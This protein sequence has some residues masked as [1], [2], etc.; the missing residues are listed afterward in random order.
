M[1][2]RLHLFADEY[3]VGLFHRLGRSQR[4]VRATIVSRV[5]PRLIW[6][7]SDNDLP[8]RYPWCFVISNRARGRRPLYVGAFLTIPTTAGKSSLVVIYASVSYGWLK[9]NMQTEFPIT[10][11]A[12]R[13][14]N[15]VTQRD[16]A[17]KNWHLHRQW[18][19][20]LR[21][22][23]SALLQRVILTPAMQFKQHSQ[24]LLREGSQEDY[25]ICS[26]DGV[27]L[28]PWKNWPDCISQEAGVWIWRQSR[29]RK[30]LDSQRIPLGRA[31]AKSPDASF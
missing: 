20:A 2:L 23:C 10:F 8:A 7:M 18:I 22:S 13:V 1:A 3:Q 15:G 6:S 31:E 29:H 21:W 30:V 27:E 16:V 25:R 12:A 5:L 24:V 14:L 26:S 9:K 17:E 19:K 4:Q 28:M 11:W